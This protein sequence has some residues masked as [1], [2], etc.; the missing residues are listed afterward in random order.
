MGETTVTVFDDVL[1][2]V[3][4]EH[5][6]AKAKHGIDHVPSWHKMSN[7]DRLVIVV[8]EL[9]E[10]ARA[11]TYDEGNVD[12]LIE[13]LIQLAAMAAASAAGVLKLQ[14]LRRIESAQP[15]ATRR[16]SLPPL[17]VPTAS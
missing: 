12:K 4:K 3:F 1:D 14:Q 16:A 11:M 6:R 2:R 17:F 8:E 13:E 7:P 5:E 15:P 10:V 9:G